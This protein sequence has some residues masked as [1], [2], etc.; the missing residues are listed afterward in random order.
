M[1][2]GTPV[3]VACTNRQLRDDRVSLYIVRYNPVPGQSLPTASAGG[4]IDDRPSGMGTIEE[5]AW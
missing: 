2:T 1:V 3:L 5:L 4:K